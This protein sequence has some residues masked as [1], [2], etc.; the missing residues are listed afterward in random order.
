MVKV[1]DKDNEESEDEVVSRMS[2]NVG[3]VGRV[4]W[5]GG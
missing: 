1:S 5:N 4:A 2:E 3:N